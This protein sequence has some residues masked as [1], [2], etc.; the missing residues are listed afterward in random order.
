MREKALN[1]DG[2]EINK[3]KFYASKQPKDLNLADVHK[4]VKA[5]RIE[6]AYKNFKY[7]IGYADGGSIRPL[8]IKLPQMSGSKNILIAVVKICL[9][10][11]KS[12]VYSERHSEP[13]YYNKEVKTKVKTFNAAVHTNFHDE[14]I[15]KENMHYVCL[16]I[17]SADSVMRMDEK[18]TLKYI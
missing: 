10:W 18:T 1:F 9:S 3:Q 17:V 6:Y 12:I 14:K 5:S 8:C 13:I 15:P 11:S 16:M 4:I 2:V 7:F